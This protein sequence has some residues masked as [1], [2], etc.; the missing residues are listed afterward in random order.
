MSDIRIIPVTTKKGL[1]TF[2][3]FYYDLYEGSKYAVPYLRFDE[4]NTLSKDKNPAFDFCEA[5]YFLAID[6]L[7]LIHI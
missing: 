7:S 6:Y 3:Q 1:R 4:W 2:I 5:Q